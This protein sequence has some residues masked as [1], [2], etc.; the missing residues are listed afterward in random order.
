[1]II[2]RLFSI[3]KIASIG[4]AIFLAF[5]NLSPSDVAHAQSP[6][7]SANAGSTTAST[8]PS[9]SSGDQSYLQSVYQDTWQYMADFVEPSTGLP[10]DSNKKQPATSI[11]NVGL[12]LASTAI[13]FRTNLIDSGEATK[14]IDAALGSLEKIERWEGF[15]RV[16]VTAR[17]LKPIHGTEVFSYSKH[18]SNLI[19]G[20]VIAQTTFPDQFETRIGNYMRGM[21]FRGMYDAA[22]G[23]LK[24]GYDVNS[25]NYAVS[26]PFGPWHYKFLASEARLI[27]FYM[28][29]RG[30]APESHWNALTRPIQREN[31][32]W[33][34]VDGYETGGA[35]MPYMASLYIDERPTLMGVSQKNYTQSQMNLAQEIGAPVWGWSAS[36][37]TRGEY[38]PYGQLKNELVAPYASILAINHYPQEVVSNLKALEDLG[39]RYEE[40]VQRDT[41]LPVI[42]T[43]E[44]GTI[45]TWAAA[46]DGEVIFQDKTNQS[47]KLSDYLDNTQKDI[48]TWSDENGP[49]T[50]LIRAAGYRVR[51][52]DTVNN[53]IEY[54]TTGTLVRKNLIDQLSHPKELDQLLGLA[55][56]ANLYFPGE[57]KFKDGTRLNVAFMRENGHA[58]PWAVSSVKDVYFINKN[59]SIR[60]FTN[61]LDKE[62]SNQILNGNY[63][64]ESLTQL[65]TSLGYET[66]PENIDQF[67]KEFKTGSILGEN[68][69]AIV[70]T[71]TNGQ[72][73]LSFVERKKE[74]HLTDVKLEDTTRAK[75]LFTETEV[76]TPWALGREQQISFINKENAVEKIAPYLESTVSEFQPITE[77]NFDRSSVK[78]ILNSLGYEAEAEKSIDSLIESIKFGTLFDEKLVDQFSDPV[79]VTKLLGLASHLGQYEVGQI[80][81]VD[82]SEHKVI[83][84]LSQG[85]IKAYEYVEKEDSFFRTNEGLAESIGGFINALQS[86]NKIE[87]Y[88]KE[89]L[90]DLQEDTRIFNNISEISI[91]SDSLETTPATQVIIPTQAGE[92]LSLGE[93]NGSYS[94][95]EIKL[96]NGKTVAYGF[97]DSIDWKSGK[98]T[99]F[100]LTPSQG[101]AFLS[102]A[103]ALY[104]GVVWKSF[105]EGHKVSRGLAI[106][107]D[108]TEEAKNIDQQVDHNL[109]TNDSFILA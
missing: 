104:D 72:D 19:A 69:P 50:K 71:S 101:M 77:I 92:L 41:I 16:W 65:L 88:V 2:V 102:L 3:K 59:G 11:S 44:N 107:A 66:T 20:L 30:F 64:K 90:R 57:I 1:M 89:P 54:I 32:E 38:V 37:D 15:P 63:D 49:L 7:A 45:K 43:N 61:Y 105:A 74:Y 99:P 70:S 6:F 39:A 13:A 86:K 21:R 76:Y 68:L 40:T 42:F 87:D 48:P 62:N 96:N 75:A 46:K 27:S 51:H 56:K 55:A 108:A 106:L 95:S 78:E 80:N 28:I 9:F 91:L 67:I 18:I 82:E 36:L 10:Y 103:N 93:Q 5:G 81:L 29:A 98:V 14:R 79:Q 35:Y 12:Y 31:G 4:L 33:F 22:T 100:Y 97:R 94:P 58:K 53:L 83:F 85:S 25:N 23:W 109:C 84:T 17:G 24:G 73:T 47:Q 34:F 8:T 52:S 60:K 26:Q